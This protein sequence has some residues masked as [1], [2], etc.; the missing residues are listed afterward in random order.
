MSRF[1]AIPGY[2]FIGDTAVANDGDGR[3]ADPGDW[4][5][6]WECGF[7]NPSQPRNSS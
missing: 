7:F 2:D 5:R 1:R 6:A 3:D 4:L